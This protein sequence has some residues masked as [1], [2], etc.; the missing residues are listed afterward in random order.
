MRV[1]ITGGSGFIGRAL[2]ASL[3]ED[4]HEVIALSRRP[5]AVGGLPAGMRAVGWDGR[6]SAGWADQVEGTQIIVNLAGESLSH[7]PWTAE[8]KRR[9]LDSRVNAGRAVAEAVRK[10]RARP[11]VVIQSSGV[12][13]YGPRG[14]EEIPEDTAP[15]QDFLARL[16]VEWEASSVE[17]EA[18][19]VRRAIIR[20]GLPLSLRGGVFPLMRLPFLFMVGGPLGSGRQGIPWIHLEDHVRAIRFLIDRPD[21]HGAFNLAAPQPCTNRQFARTLGQVMHRPSIVPVP[22]FAMRLML[23]EMAGLILTGQR[24]IPA[25]LA[26]MGFAFKFADLEQALRDVLRG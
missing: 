11:H 13:Y 26:E 7:W 18:L 4:S 10:V 14:T 8:R 9:F 20:T 1:L 2:G 5:D 25:R 21:A 16:A 23:G 17:V 3:T 15:G 24:A 12:G 19:G 22:G 6:S